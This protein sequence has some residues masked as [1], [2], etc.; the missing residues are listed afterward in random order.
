LAF[1][2]NYLWTVDVA[3]LFWMS[4]IKSIL[5]VGVTLGVILYFRLSEDVHS[6]VKKVLRPIGVKL[7]D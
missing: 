1:L 4:V 6:M 2:V 7:N 5:L 3:N